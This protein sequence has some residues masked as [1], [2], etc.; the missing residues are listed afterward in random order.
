MDKK[1]FSLIEL[2]VVMSVI[3]ILGVVA[4]TGYIGT[5]LKAARTEAYTN[6]QAIRLQEEQNFAET[7]L[8]VAAVGTVALQGVLP[9]F[10]PGAGLN[11]NYSVT[12]IAAGT[13]LP[14]PV[15]VP[16]AGQTAP[17]LNAATPCFI[18]TATGLP[19][20]RVQGDVFA[21]DCNNNRNF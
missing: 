7:S 5:Q 14:T 18:A 20:T 8:Y 17:L 15:P 2:L 21:I 19:G 4:V 13:G 12:S 11:Y 6:L 9:R 10:R 3:G 1:G 16:Y